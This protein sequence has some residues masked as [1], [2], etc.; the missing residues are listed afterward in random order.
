MNPMKSDEMTAHGMIFILSAV[1]ADM[2]VEATI[3]H[4]A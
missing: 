3:A 4:A 1:P 2:M